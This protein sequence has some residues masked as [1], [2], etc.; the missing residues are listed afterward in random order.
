MRGLESEWRRRITSVYWVLEGRWRWG[1]GL[2]SGIID[3]LTQLFEGLFL[4]VY[5]LE[6][7]IYL[8]LLKMHLFMADLNLLLLLSYLLDSLFK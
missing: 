7:F 1:E 6:S 3:G 8:G 2:L 4:A 5:L